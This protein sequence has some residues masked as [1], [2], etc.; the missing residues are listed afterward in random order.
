MKNIVGQKSVY[1]INTDEH[2]ME[3]EYVSLKLEKSK[4]K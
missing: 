2:S 4:R 3:A 1:T